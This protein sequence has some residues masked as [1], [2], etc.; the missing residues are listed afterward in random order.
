MQLDLFSSNYDCCIG[1]QLGWNFK[2]LDNLLAVANIHHQNHKVCVCVCLNNRDK[3]FAHLHGNQ[4]FVRESFKSFKTSPFNIAKL[5]IFLI[6]KG[7]SAN[8]KCFK[9]VHTYTHYNY[10]MELE[11]CLELTYHISNLRSIVIYTK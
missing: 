3:K 2:I 10:G 9:C 4:V 5:M 8:P 1:Q 11:V 7:S 6:E